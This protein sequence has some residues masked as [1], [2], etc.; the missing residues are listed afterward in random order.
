[1]EGMVREAGMTREGDGALVVVEVADVTMIDGARG[2]E[3]EKEGRA[4]KDWKAGEGCD[5]EI[6]GVSTC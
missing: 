2:A 3:E 5:D 4:G 6:A 1:M